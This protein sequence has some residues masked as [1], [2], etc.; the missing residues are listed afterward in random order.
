MYDCRTRAD[1]ADCHAVFFSVAQ[2]GADGGQLHGAKIING[3]SLLFSGG[4]FCVYF[5]S[6]R[7]ADLRFYQR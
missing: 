6:L 3:A 1:S 5:F 7:R 2:C 4:Y